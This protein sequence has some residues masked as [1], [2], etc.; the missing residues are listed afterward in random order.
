MTHGQKDAFL[1][2]GVAAGAAAIGY[3]VANHD[4][5]IMPWA[6]TTRERALRLERLLHSKGVSTTKSTSLWSWTLW[7]VPWWLL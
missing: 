6:E 2:V 5:G 7:S 1:L 4:Q 3:Y